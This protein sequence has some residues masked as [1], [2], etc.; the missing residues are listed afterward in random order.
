MIK[1]NVL[2]LIMLVFGVAGCAMESGADLPG[3]VINSKEQAI[4]ES[5]PITHVAIRFHTGGDDKRAG[6]EVNFQLKMNSGSVNS[7]D[8]DDAAQWPNNSSTGYFYGQVPVNTVYG[9]IDQLGVQMFSHNG[10][11]QTDD[12]WNMDGFDLWVGL[13]DGSWSFVSSPSGNPL[14]RFTGQDQQFWSSWP[15]GT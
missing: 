5:Q 13:P 7:Y 3:G 10:F 6:S 15:A 2:G 1:P 4:S 9:D 14:K 11:V 12:N 8:T